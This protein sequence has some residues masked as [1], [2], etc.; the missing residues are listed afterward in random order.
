[1][2]AYVL[3]PLPPHSAPAARVELLLGRP[4]V[5]PVGLPE[6]KPFRSLQF[7]RLV[8]NSARTHDDLLRGRAEAA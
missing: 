6:R 3:W 7:Q 2:D 1:M 5:C 4:V 8:D